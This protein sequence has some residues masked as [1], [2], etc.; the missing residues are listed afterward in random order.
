[1]II[2]R[3][4]LSEI[5]VVELR[6]TKL[7]HIDL[8]EAFSYNFVSSTS[9]EI[10]FSNSFEFKKFLLNATKKCKRRDAENGVT[11]KDLNKRGHTK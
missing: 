11:L 1:M 4:F 5:K 3:Y 6:E 2:S 10:N 7:N 9:K 8:F